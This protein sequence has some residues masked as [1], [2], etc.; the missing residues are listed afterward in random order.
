M[1][2]TTSEKKTLQGLFKGKFRFSRTKIFLKESFT[3]FTVRASLR[4]RRRYAVTTKEYTKIGC[5]RTELLFHVLSP[6]TRE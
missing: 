3:I 1:V 5:F 6:S 4:P 2:C